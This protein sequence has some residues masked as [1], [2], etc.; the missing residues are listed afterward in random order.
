MRKALAILAVL[1]V[2]LP[3]LGMDMTDPGVQVTIIY[4]DENSFQGN[5]WMGYTNNRKTG[6]AQLSSWGDYDDWE[7]NRYMNG[8]IGGYDRAEVQAAI[9]LNVALYGGWDAKVLL[10][11][12]T[13]VGVPAGFDP[14]VGLFSA[15]LPEGET[16]TSFYDSLSMNTRDVFGA[17]D[18]TYGGTA[19]A[20]FE[21]FADT[22]VAGGDGMIL[23]DQPWYQW[24]YND[25][26]AHNKVVVKV[27]NAMIT[28]YLT[29]EDITG[30]F[31]SN[32]QENDVAMD[33]YAGNQWTGRGF[34][35]L[36]ITPEPATLLLIAVG[37]VGLVLRRKR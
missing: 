1:G 13:W 15:D 12:P 28:E 22:C 36:E 27:P 14:V 34:M 25:P 7:T 21:D 8:V 26:I 32:K 10:T 4:G 3:A 37:G 20:Q 11:H 18:W 5:G 24:I 30:F 35:V 33:H 19:Y 23:E 17:D 16:V 29:N 31:A 6:A 9:D 2:T